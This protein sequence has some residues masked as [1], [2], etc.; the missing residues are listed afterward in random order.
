MTELTD[1]QLENFGQRLRAQREA[2]RGIPQD[3]PERVPPEPYAELA[4]A[5]HDVGDE[6]FAELETGV[7]L[8]ARQHERKELQDVES[9][10]TRIRAKTYGV[11]I[12]CAAAVTVER[13]QVYP[14]AK[15]CITC[16]SRHENRRGGRDA[17]PS[18]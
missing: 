3:D 8:T 7:N 12:D 17:T 6:S 14:T 4:G 11:C 16:Q 1:K 10:L 2:L 18:L 9:A 5:V 15:R 13:L